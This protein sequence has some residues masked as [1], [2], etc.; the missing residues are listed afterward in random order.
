MR[1]RVFIP[2]LAIILGIG[3]A[4]IPHPIWAQ[5]GG[6]SD[7]KIRDSIEKRLQDHKLITSTDIEVTV[8]EKNV[9][10][11]GTVQ[12]IDQK[13]VI[14]AQARK[15]AKGYSIVNNLQI[16]PSG[17]NDWQLTDKVLKRFED[18]IFYSIFDWVGI[19][20]NNGVATLT[21]WVR[22][23]WDKRAYEHEIQKVA[24]ITKIDNQIEIESGSIFD[25]EV[26]AQAARMIYGDSRFDPYA[27]SGGAPIHIVVNNGSVFLEGVVARRDMRSWAENT[28]YSNT[29]ALRVVDDL[30]VE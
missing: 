8:T 3:V 21:G 29:K 28:V 23:P 13:N 6:N 22:Q 2:L 11:T 7:Q 4:I 12:D 25:D 18:N 26:R 9:A 20:V 19:D 17:L 15:A 24:G 14:E 16:A 27:S 5:N 10:I 1:N 30:K